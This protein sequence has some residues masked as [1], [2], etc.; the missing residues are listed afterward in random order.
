MT[1]G[2]KKGPGR[3]KQLATCGSSS[4]V[5]RLPTPPRIN[6]SSVEDVRREMAR[7]Y[8]D[9]RSG[10]LATQDGTRLTYV[11]DRMLN[12]FELIELERRLR[13]LEDLDEQH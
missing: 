5:A 2:M 11:L 8:R 10:K 4:R 13:A 3:T 9:M 12:A 6:L 7:V 1:G